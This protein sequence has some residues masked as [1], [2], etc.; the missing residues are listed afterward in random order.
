MSPAPI[1]DDG[2]P[3]I[4]AVNQT[5]PNPASG[6][7]RPRSL[8]GRR[9]V[10]ATPTATWSCIGCVA[11]AGSANIDAR[12]MVSPRRTDVESA[13]SGGSPRPEITEPG[14]GFWATG[15]DGFRTSGALGGSSRPQPPGATTDNAR[16]NDADQ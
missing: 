10:S 8:I 2:C 6:G 13:T 16:M 7:T 11:V 15:F 5:R 14:N 1:I 4:Q 9:V 12:T 3:D